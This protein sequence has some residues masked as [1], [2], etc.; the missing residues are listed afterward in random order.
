MLTGVT[1]LLSVKSKLDMCLLFSLSPTK[2]TNLSLL[3][4]D[5]K[6]TLYNNDTHCSQSTNNMPCLATV[7]MT[8]RSL[9]LFQEVVL[10]E[11]MLFI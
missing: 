1:L 4:Q 10:A 5:I 9:A 7:Q 2:S 6:P 3:P 8:E 11:L